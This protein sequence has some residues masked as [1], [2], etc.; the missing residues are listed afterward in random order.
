MS[1]KV[2]QGD[3]FK[4]SAQTLV[5][6]VN[7]VGAMGKVIAL[8][9]KKR[10][11]TMYKRYMELC[12]QGHIK[13]GSLWLYKAD[14]GKWILNFPTKDDWRNPSDIDYIVQGL[15]KFIDTYKQKGI[16]SIAFP[17]LGCNNGG[18]DKATV[19]MMMK[20]HLETCEDLDVEIY[21]NPD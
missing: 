13:I 4:S 9:F 2:V 8:E 11:P 17:M 12:N 3:L 18:L 5:N 1:V 7:C 16:T 6:T 20:M 10:Y 15:D 21:Y 19:L 14:D